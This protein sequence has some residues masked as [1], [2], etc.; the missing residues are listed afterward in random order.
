MAVLLSSAP[1]RVW[2]GQRLAQGQ[3]EADVTAGHRAFDALAEGAEVDRSAAVTA[4]ESGRGACGRGGRHFEEGCV[5]VDSS[6][7]AAR[8]ASSRTSRP[9]SRP[10][11]VVTG[12]FSSLCARMYSAIS[13][14]ATCG[15]NVLG[16]G[17][18]A[19]LIEFVG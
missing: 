19:S 8:S 13:V 16:P 4:G 17:R 7:R 9:T 11:D 5:V 2:M 3:A 1:M 15:R 12:E 6:S 10:S 18:M 14:I